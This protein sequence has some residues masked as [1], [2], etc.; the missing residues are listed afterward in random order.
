MP[1]LR[2]LLTL[3]ALVLFL[4]VTLAQAGLPSR[5]QRKVDAS[6]GVL[7][8]LAT[9]PEVRIPQGILA[10]A[11]CLVVMPQV[12]KGALLLGGR[13]GKGLAACRLPDRSWGPP[14]FVEMGGVSYGLQAGVEVLDLVLV[15]RKREGI[16]SLLKDNLKLGA[17][18]SVAAG[19]QGANVSA[20]TDAAFKATILSYARSSGAFIGLSLDGAVL[21]RNGRDN[22][23]LYGSEVAS[24]AVLLPAPGKALKVPAAARP[25]QEALIKYAPAQ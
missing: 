19:P 17:E 15:V 9:G 14:L 7:R 25:F 22:E 1:H 24:R 2:R 21:R 12:T 13:F 3:T 10:Q 18:A 20:Q 16:E 8:E 4:G 6:A 5:L 23:R 11:E